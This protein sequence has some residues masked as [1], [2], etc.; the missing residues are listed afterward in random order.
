MR[1]LLLIL[2]AL[3]AGTSMA[4]AFELNHQESDSV[5]AALGTIWGNYIHKKAPA[6]GQAVSDEYLRGVDEALKLAGTNDAYLQGLVEAATMLQRI[7]QVEQLGGFKVDRERFAYYLL[8]G[9]R[10]K[11][12]GFTPATADNYMNYIITAANHEDNR[13]TNDSLYMQRE[14]RREGVVTTPS[15][16][17]F[18]VITEGEGGKPGPTDDVMVRY[19]GALTDGTVFNKTDEGRSKVFQVNNVIPGF[20][21]GLQMMKKGGKYR[22]IIPSRLGYGEKGV[23]GVVP[24][25]AV[26]VFT[27]ELLDYRPHV[28]E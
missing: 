3:L 4:S 2:A 17:L 9:A 8:R 16:L 26:T 25:D 15:G 21:E 12:T 13:R 11:N 20:S 10:G 24:N 1:K 6:E 23:F 28:D 18:E 27:V 19:T 7:E 22:L 5:S 14:A